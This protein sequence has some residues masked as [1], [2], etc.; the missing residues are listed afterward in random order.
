MNENPNNAS[1]PQG[2]E[3]TP[4]HA[5]PIN[6]LYSGRLG[7]LSGI[8]TSSPMRNASWQ[9]E[10]WV[11]LVLFAILVS[12]LIGSATQSFLIGSVSFVSIIAFAICINFLLTKLRASTR[13][14]GNEE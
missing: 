9:A 12:T 4:G 10:I 3:T 6:P 7:R 14:T 2:R 11:F 8:G 5:R 13:R 1:G